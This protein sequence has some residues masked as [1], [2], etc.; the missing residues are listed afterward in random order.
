MAFSQVRRG[1]RGCAA[2]VSP[3]PALLGNNLLVCLFASGFPPGDGAR[4]RGSRRA[5]LASCSD[6]CL[7][8]SGASNVRLVRLIAVRQFSLV[9]LFVLAGAGISCELMSGRREHIASGSSSAA[10]NLDLV[11]SLG[12]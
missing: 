4:R 5:L 8:I 10:A 12:G 3:S 1:Y 9:H 6:V 11:M 7:W 2:L